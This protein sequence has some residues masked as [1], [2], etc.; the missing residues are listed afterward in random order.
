LW[1][2]ID[3]I[4][5]EADEPFPSGPFVHDGIRIEILALTEDARPAAVSFR[6]PTPLED[7]H[8]RWLQWTRD[9]FIAF[10]PPPVG[11]SVRLVTYIE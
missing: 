9:G 3:W 6:F 11:Q 10:Q 7:P 5:R 1:Q 4:Y 2:T 8:W